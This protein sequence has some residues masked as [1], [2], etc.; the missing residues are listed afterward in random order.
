MQAEIKKCEKNSLGDWEQSCYDITRQMLWI[1]N[2]LLKIQW[3]ELVY[4]T[5]RIAYTT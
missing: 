1:W 5:T 3:Y 4:T 2:E